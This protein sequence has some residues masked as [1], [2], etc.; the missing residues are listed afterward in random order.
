MALQVGIVGLPNVGKS[1]LF[2]ALTSAK[3]EAA[4][5]P[6]CTIDPNVGVV[7]VPDP[8]MD[9]IT[10]FIKPQKVV[11]TTME[12]VDI[13]GIVKGASQGEGLG[14]QFLSHI[15]QTDAIV[16]VV[17]CF[18]DP[19]IIHVAGSVEPIRD[20]EIINT[21]LLLADLDS[22]EKRLQ[23]TEKQAKNSTDKKLKLDV[24]VAK[25][26][27]E[28]L[29]KGLPAR[30]VVLDEMEQVAL[31]EM[32]L[33]TAKPVLYAMNV[34]DADFAAGGND[35]T[36]AVEARAAEE[37]NKTILICSAMEAEIALLPPEERKDFLDALGA[38]EPGLNRLIREAY[39]LLGLQTY[40]TAGVTEVRAWTIRANTKAPQ[41]AG[42][43][44]SDFERG[45]IKAETYHCEDLFKYKSEQA[46]KDAGKYRIEG[47][48]YVV[49]DGDVLFFKFNV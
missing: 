46:I 42:V 28:A 43:I 13:A 40:F 10:E 3:A 11:P 27:K 8:R 47:K 49:K 20:I 38:E 6:F 44:H 18:D 22:V 34:N 25:K 29:G 31:K 30:A 23:R 35:W 19:N 45:F 21:E 16:H 12:F 24:E 26:I 2:N 9:K 41:A 39:T 48:E 17:R 36:K 33:L 14:N 7:T 32:H 37:N 15:R 4:N 5:Y 1:T